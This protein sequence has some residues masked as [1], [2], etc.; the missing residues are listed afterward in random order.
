MELADNHSPV[1]EE[2]LM[3]RFICYFFTEI[4]CECKNISE[5]QYFVFLFTK[6]NEKIID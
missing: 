5:Y 3:A 4:K 6:I 2:F 1:R